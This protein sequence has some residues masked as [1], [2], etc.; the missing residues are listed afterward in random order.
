MVFIEIFGSQFDFFIKLI[1][2][3]HKSY[4]DTRKTLGYKKSS[5]YGS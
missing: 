1:L 3:N 5:Y 2:S 4:D